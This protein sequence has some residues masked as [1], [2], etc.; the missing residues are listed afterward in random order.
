[1][2]WLAAAAVL[3]LA[4][5][6]YAALREPSAPSPVPEPLPSSEPE[7][8]L[9]PPTPA[10]LRIQ[11][12]GECAAELWSECLRDLDQARTL[13]PAGDLKP[14]VKSIREK[15]NRGLAGKPKP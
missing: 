15:A 7:P 4:T 10:T 8:R 6:L 14:D 5:A 13:D 11:A 3:L 2:V 12:T 9:P 1:V